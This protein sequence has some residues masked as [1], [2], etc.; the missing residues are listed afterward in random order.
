MI[1]RKS[2]K[3]L[4]KE[5]SDIQEQLNAIEQQERAIAVEKQRELDE[6]ARVQREKD[7]LERQFHLSEKPLVRLLYLIDF[8]VRTKDLTVV[9]S[10]GTLK[11]YTYAELLKLFNLTLSHYK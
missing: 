11:K 5:A 1:G 4:V 3:D 7:N 2:K 6:I 8:C 10:D 9:N